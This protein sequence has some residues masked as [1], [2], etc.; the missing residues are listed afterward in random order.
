VR[1]DFND[2]TVI[3]TLSK[4]NLLA[5]LQKADD[6]LSAKALVSGNAYRDGEETDGLGLV[7]ICETDAQ[8]YGK[9]RH[10]AGVMHPVTEAF[11]ARL[12]GADGNAN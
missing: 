7:V 4:R 2:S 3:V 8:H 12:T 5:L 1:L 9:R 10:P 6:P 11:I